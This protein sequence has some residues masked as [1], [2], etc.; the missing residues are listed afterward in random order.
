V[1][2]LREDQVSWL[3]CHNRAFE[4]L[5]GIPAVNRIDNVKTAIAQGSGA[6]GTIHP[7][8]RAY[9]RSVGFHVDACE[10][11]SPEHKG[12]VEAKVRLSRRILE[13]LGT[14]FD[15]LEDLQQQT[16]RR[17]EHWS[18]R[19][20]CPATGKSV[21]ASWEAELP[22]L[23]ALPLLPEPFDVAVLR[24][25]HKDC[26]V[27]FEQRQYAVPFVHVGRHVE[28]RGCAGKVQIFAGS[29]L[30]REYPRHSA[31]RILI[32]PSCYEG[33]STDRVKAPTPLGRMGRK[34]A[35]IYSMPVAQRPLDLYAALAE[36][37]R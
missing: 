20:T 13:P 9:A 5:G 16:D 33:S 26:M 28:V 30:V 21:R 35:E 6:W 31:E 17:I 37:A 2:S 7:T 11:E 22:L 29:K 14:R 19:A 18:E 36:V 1:W 27:H 23:Q 12:K 34:L 24:P 25:V 32:D 15:S 3:A 4:R 10:A 8:Y